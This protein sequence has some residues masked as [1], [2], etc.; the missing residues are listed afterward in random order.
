VMLGC[1]GLMW[2]GLFWLLASSSPLEHKWISASERDY[3]VGTL[4]GQLETTVAE[5]K[6]R[7]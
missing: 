4:S 6:V 7:I 1:L 3:I 2:C 5:R